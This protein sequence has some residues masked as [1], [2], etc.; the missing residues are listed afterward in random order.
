MKPSHYYSE[1]PFILLGLFTNLVF[2][3]NVGTRALRLLNTGGT[4]PD[5]NLD[6]VNLAKIIKDGQHL[7]S[8]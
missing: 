7:C 6:K 1:L 4:T 5:A 8:V 2:D 3:V